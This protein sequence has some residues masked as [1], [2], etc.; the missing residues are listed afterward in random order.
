MLSRFRDPR[1][2]LTVEQAV[3]EGYERVMWVFRA[4]DAI[5]G[6]ASKL[7]FQWERIRPSPGT[8]LSLQRARTD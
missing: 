3:T 8:M 2:S 6:A 7:P 1:A 4:V 5:A